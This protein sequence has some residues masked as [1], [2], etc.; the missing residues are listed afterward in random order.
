MIAALGMYDRPELR[1]STDLY[2]S[3]IRDGLR[4]RGIDAP[5]ALT[6]D[7]RAWSDKQGES[8]YLST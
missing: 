8:H 4:K 1:A 3:L 2:W 6:R 5:D 7:E